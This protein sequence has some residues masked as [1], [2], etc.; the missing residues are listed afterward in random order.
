MFSSTCFWRN[1]CTLYFI[2]GAFIGHWTKG[3]NTNST[4]WCSIPAAVLGKIPE[5]RQKPFLIKLQS[6]FLYFLEYTRE[7]SEAIYSRATDE[8]FG[9]YYCKWA[10][11]WNGHQ[12]SHLKIARKFSWYFVN[13]Q[14]FIRVFLKYLVNRDSSTGIFLWNLRI[15]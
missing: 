11:L 14:F 1:S 12:K 7:R 6:C 13:G 15:F 3:I 10:L 2:I 4:G 8:I 5:K 9:R